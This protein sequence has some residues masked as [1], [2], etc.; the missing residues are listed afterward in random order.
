MISEFPFPQMETA[1]K[2]LDVGGISSVIEGPGGFYIIKL[3][4]KKGGAIQEYDAIKDD[5]VAGLTL[6]KQ[7]QAILKELDDLQQKT[8]IEVNENLL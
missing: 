7:Q 8:N 3:E 6:M 4:D 5:I 1:A 2:T